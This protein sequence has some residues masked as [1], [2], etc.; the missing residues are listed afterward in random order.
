MFHQKNRDSGLSRHKY[1]KRCRKA[2]RL[3][4]AQRIKARKKKAFILASQKWI[5]ARP[6][7]LEDFV[8]G[9]DMK[10]MRKRLG[11]PIHE[12]KFDE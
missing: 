3:I 7:T 11:T 5:I 1:C 4:F 9:E 2:D 8:P 12:I 6:L 10:S